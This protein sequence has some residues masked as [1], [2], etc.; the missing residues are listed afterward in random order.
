MN[1]TASA[2][3]LRQTRD[4]VRAANRSPQ[5]EGIAGQR[6][7]GDEFDRDLPETI[8]QDIQQ[9][10]AENLQF[11]DRLALVKAFLSALFQNGNGSGSRSG[12]S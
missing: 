8:R 12:D 11:P 10:L 6:N 9:R 5:R 3:E 1:S 4:F 7:L 2:R